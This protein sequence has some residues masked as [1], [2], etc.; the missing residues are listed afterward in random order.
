[1]EATRQGVAKEAGGCAPLF[2]FLSVRR[3]AAI[4]LVFLECIVATLLVISKPNYGTNTEYRHPHKESGVVLA[5]D[6]EEKASNASTKSRNDSPRWYTPFKQPE[7]WLVIVGA[8]TFGVIAWQAWET[9]RSVYAATISALAAK[10]NADALVSSER[11]WVIVE[12]KLE[13][14]EPIQRGVLEDGTRRTCVRVGIVCRNAGPTP[15]WVYEQSV[16]VKITNQV[17]FSA[18]KYPTPEMSEESPSRQVFYQIH[19]LTGD[20]DPIVSKAWICCE[21][22]ELKGFQTYVYGYIKYRD[23]FASDR[24]TWFGYSVQKGTLA[25]YLERIPNAA[26]NKNL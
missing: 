25:R 13:G 24:I 5:A 14:D 1:M 15:A 9:R 2:Y 17:I 7:G 11:A 3:V 12:L 19:P 22:W 6:C 10:L 18:T 16:R 26:Y 21:G 20:M 8:L 4:L 23:A